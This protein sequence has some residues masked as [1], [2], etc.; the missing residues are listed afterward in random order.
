MTTI[1]ELCKHGQAGVQEHPCSG[2]YEGDKFEPADDQYRN[3]RISETAAAT[4]QCADRIRQLLPEE[5]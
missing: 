3:L 1:C 5:L 2:C 4:D